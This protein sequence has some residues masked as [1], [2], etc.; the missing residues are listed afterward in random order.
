M[1]KRCLGLLLAATIAAFAITPAWAHKPAPASQLSAMSVLPVAVSV[2][3]PA[4]LLS[5]TA[6]LTVVAVEAGAAGTAW[7]LERASDGARISLN[8]SGELAQGAVVASGAVV[9]VTA[10]AAGWVLSS[11]GQALCFV[12]NARGRTLT[13]HERVTL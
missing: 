11:A 2:A 8:L 12:P 6:T 10:L 4:L 7:V 9:T 13:H 3:A 1:N 5:G